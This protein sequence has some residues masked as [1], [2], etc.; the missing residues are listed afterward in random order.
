MALAR[1]SNSSGTVVG[2]SLTYNHIVG[3]GSNRLLVVF[4]NLSTNPGGGDVVTGVTY[5]GVAM[6]QVTK[7]NNSDATY[8]NRWN[9]AYILVNPDVGTHSVVVSCSSSQSIGAMSISYTGAK[10]T[11][12][13]DSY[14]SG[15]TASA[16]SHTINT[17]VVASNCWLAGVATATLTRPTAGSGFTTSYNDSAGNSL[18]GDTNGTVG[19]G[20]QGMTSSQSPNGAFTTIVLSIAPTTSVDYTAT[21]TETVTMSEPGFIKAGTKTLLDTFTVTDSIV[22]A[23]GRTFSD[24]F[25]LV[26]TYVA[27]HGHQYVATFTDTISMSDSLWSWLRNLISP[28]SKKTS[29]SSSWTQETDTNTDWTR[30]T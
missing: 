10:Q 15:T 13:P 16:A 11:G 21:F 17:T 27:Y 7:L 18:Y 6:T 30:K 26:E 20:S 8:T 23:L 12:Q 9:Y 5:N 29:T 1:D 19:T 14:N 22:K 25:S 28:F 2:T 4:V 3:S 24:T